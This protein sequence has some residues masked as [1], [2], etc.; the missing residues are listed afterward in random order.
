[1]N[2]KTQTKLK[3]HIQTDQQRKLVITENCEAKPEI[4]TLY[5][6][7]IYGRLGYVF[8]IASSI[9]FFFGVCQTKYNVG[10]VAILTT[11]FPE[12]LNKLSNRY[13]QL[14]HPRRKIIIRVDTCNIY[15]YLHKLHINTRIVDT[16]IFNTYDF[17]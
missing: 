16:D 5:K 12:L 10:N 13:I 8:S 1:M 9:R 3:A 4:Y 6:I 14:S 7:Y 15:I 17:R 11:H 2:F